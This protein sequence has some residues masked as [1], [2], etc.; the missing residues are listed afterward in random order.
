MEGNSYK[1]NFAR[2]LDEREQYQLFSE[3]ADLTLSTWL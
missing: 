2:S 1:P 3:M